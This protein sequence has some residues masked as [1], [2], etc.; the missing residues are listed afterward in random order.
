MLDHYL[1]ETD[2][3]QRTRAV[4]DTISV[5]GDISQNLKV[6]SYCQ[7]V[8]IVWVGYR[9]VIALGKFDFRGEAAALAS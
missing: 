8:L 6:P 5:R 3:Q 7:F 4:R 1:T 2:K 9:K